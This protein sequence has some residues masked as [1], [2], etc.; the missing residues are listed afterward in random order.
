ME[1]TVASSGPEGITFRAPARNALSRVASSMVPLPSA[2]VDAETEADGVAV[3]V[4]LGAAGEASA[5]EGEAVAPAWEEQPVSSKMAATPRVAN[6]RM[7]EF[8]SDDGH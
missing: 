2:R 4:G 3:C 6:L 5:A 7:F 1:I 8:I